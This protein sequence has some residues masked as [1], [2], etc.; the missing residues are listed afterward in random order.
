[1]TTMV[2]ADVS[3]DVDVA[4]ERVEHYRAL[5]KEERSVEDAAIGR[6]FA[7]AARGKQ[8]I[9]LNESIR[10]GGLDEL[11]RPRLAVCRATST[12]VECYIG[13]S[14]RILF[15]DDKRTQ[16]T[17]SM[18]QDVG[19]QYVSVRWPDREPAA[20]SYRRQETWTAIVPNVPP[21]YRPPRRHRLSGTTGD[22]LACCHIVWEAEWSSVAPRDPA[23][24]RRIGGDLWEVIATWDLTELERAVIV[25]TRSATS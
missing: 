15:M 20:S 1:M 19:A 22:P 2:L 8:I 7:V 17:W 16:S 4:K 21:E 5:R 13:G 6:A 9:M 12:R 25:G 24:I 23:L 3:V 18:H 10:A 11:G 14:Q